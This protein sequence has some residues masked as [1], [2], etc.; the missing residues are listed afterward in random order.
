MVCSVI[1]ALGKAGEWRGAL[2]MI[3]DLEAEEGATDTACYNAALTALLRARRDDD[4]LELIHRMKSLGGRCRPNRITFQI[5]DR[6]APPE[7]RST[8]ARLR[9]A[10]SGDH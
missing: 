6:F 10:T 1:S 7:L 9:T 8:V 5:V 3:Y 4:G 2:T